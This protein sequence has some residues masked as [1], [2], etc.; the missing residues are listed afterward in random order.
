M[1][2]VVESHDHGHH[3]P[4]KGLSRWLFTTNHKDIGTLYLWFSF[5]MLFIGGGMAMVIRAE[6]FQPGLQIVQPEFFNQMTTNH[7]LIMVF[8]VIMPA[9]VGLAN[10]M[11]PMQIGA[12]DMALPRLNNLSFWLLPMAFGILIS[13][14]FMPEGG[15]NFGW[16]FYA[17]LST[18]YAPST[19]NFFIFSV[20]VMGVSSILGSINIIT[21]IF[22]MRAPG[23]TLMKMPLF[24]WSWLITAYLLIAVMPVLAGVVTMML[25]DINFGTSFFNAAGGGDPV[26][27]QHV[28]WF[29]G[30]P[31]VYIMILPAF[32]IVS[33]II[34][35]FSRKPIFGYSSMVYAMAS[36]A[37][38][39]FVVWAHHMF[40]SGTPPWMRL[41]F[42]IATAFIAVPTGIKFFN[43]VATLWGG[44]ISINSA[45]LFSC[46]FIINFVFG[47]ITGVALAQVPFDIHVHD[48][49]FVVA[50]FHYIVYGGTVF[51]IFSSIYH[52]F[53]KVTGKMLSEKL[54]IFHFIITFIGFNLCFAPQ[55]WLGLNGMPRRVA[56]YD[57]QFQL[58]NQISSIGALLMAIST[59]PFLINV[60]LSVRNGKNSGDNPWNAL[61]P[62]WLTSSP[63]PVENWEGEA[64]LVEEPYG[65]GKQFSEQ[66]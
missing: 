39:S 41:F 50:H 35:T 7:G 33:H 2:T 48:T 6:L 9:F 8:G 64:P 43:W 56:E 46:G 42:T 5:I 3:G 11:L 59:I 58:V 60:F 61:T 45:M 36:I 44:K 18:T 65:Y 57:P 23:M 12:P 52:W 19:V 49:Y 4:A 27:F 55:H 62:E 66:K 17:P 54:G 47:G 26:L 13:T 34:E 28:F 31:E 38:L 15:P 24:V 20:H 21:T 32:G 1:S 29:F 16:T 10:W 22:N 30:H 14:L 53:P 63:P 51:I 37:I 25:M 40:T